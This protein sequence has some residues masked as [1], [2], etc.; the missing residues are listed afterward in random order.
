LIAMRAHILSLPACCL[1]LAGCEPPPP[2]PSPPVA[3]T[4]PHDHE[5]GFH[6]AS[7]NAV[8]DCK[9]GHAMLEI[10]GIQARL[11]LVGPDVEKLEPVPVPDA[12]ITLLVDDPVNKRKRPLVMEADPLEGQKVGR[13]S[14]F[15]VQAGWLE[16][17]VGLEATG[18]VRFKGKRRTL[19]VRFPHGYDPH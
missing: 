9:V 18:T 19:R 14:R 8:D 17:Q 4:P 16:G 7:T 1:L 10:E 5:R 15:K 13:C 3:V 2:P 12:R 6:Y 11:W